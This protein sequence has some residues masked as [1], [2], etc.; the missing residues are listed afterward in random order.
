MKIDPRLVMIAV[1][2]GPAIVQWLKDAFAKAHPGD[3]VPTS[4]E[5]IAAYGALFTSSLATDDQWLASHAAGLPE[6]PTPIA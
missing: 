2:E 5:V 6:T 3:P 4:D 1:D